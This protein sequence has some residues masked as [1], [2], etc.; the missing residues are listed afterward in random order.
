MPATNDRISNRLCSAPCAPATTPMDAYTGQT[1]PC[2][3]G[4][5]AWCSR[6]LRQACCYAHVWLYLALLQQ[7]FHPGVHQT[8]ARCAT[9]L[10]HPLQPPPAAAV[11]LP[12]QTATAPPGTPLDLPATAAA[13]PAAGP[14]IADGRHHLRDGSNGHNNM[15]YCVL[16]RGNRMVQNMKWTQLTARNQT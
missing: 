2:S 14:A 1:Y 16:Q 4:Q 7:C 15:A 6:P 10:A 9:H 8:W 3:M 11:L 13:A 5:S 12:G